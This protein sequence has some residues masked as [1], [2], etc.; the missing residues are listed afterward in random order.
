MRITSEKKID[1]S[2]DTSLA[3]KEGKPFM[4]VVFSKTLLVFHG[5]IVFLVVVL[6]VLQFVFKVGG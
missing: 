2:M 5:A 1:F 6:I 4:T 3:K